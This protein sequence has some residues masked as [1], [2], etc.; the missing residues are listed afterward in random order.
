MA[1]V[2]LLVNADAQV[3]ARN[4]ASETALDLA[5]ESRHSS[6]VT[7]LKS[8]GASKAGRRKGNV[9]QSIHQRAN[10]QPF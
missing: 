9:I 4:G 7:F 10:V 8:V 2:M 6:I 5:V 1:I 3:T